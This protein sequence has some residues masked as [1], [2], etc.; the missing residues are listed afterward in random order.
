MSESDFHT[1]AKELLELKRQIKSP[2]PV[3]RSH[4]ELCKSSHNY[5]IMQATITQ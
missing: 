1:K 2:L 3:K 4:L 5:D